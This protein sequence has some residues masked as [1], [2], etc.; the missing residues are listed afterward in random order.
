MKSFITLFILSIGY[1]MPECSFGQGRVPMSRSAF[2][3][4]RFYDHR[5]RLDPN[6]IR[7]QAL[8]LPTNLRFMYE[9]TLAKKVAIATS[10]SFQHGGQEAGTFKAE[11]HGKY[12]IS[13]I[14]PVGLYVMGTIGHW[15]IQ[16]HVFK[17]RMSDTE[18]GRKIE[19]DPTRPYVLEK[20]GSFQSLAGGLAMG[21]Q[22]ASGPGKRFL[23]DF[24][25]GYQFCA[26]PSQFRTSYTENQLVY[27]KFDANR[28][29]TGPLSPLAA[30]F[31]L[32]FLF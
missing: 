7:L 32:G 26:I 13:H 17:Y 27:G 19:Y 23:I 15:S 29:I 28:G 30:R 22:N 10:I 11:L 6:S 3:N 16:N 31:G 20:K 25:V 21:F 9:R 4:R 2:N 14:A 1:F 12:F 18:G 5:G 8:Q 24:S